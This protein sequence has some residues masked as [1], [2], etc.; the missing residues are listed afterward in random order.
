MSRIGVK[1]PSLEL[2]ERGRGWFINLTSRQR[3][4]VDCRRMIVESWYTAREIGFAAGLR[5]SE[6]TPAFILQMASVLPPNISRETLYEWRRLFNADGAF[7]LIDL[8]WL[9]S[10]PSAAWPF[11]RTLAA[12]Y[13]RSGK[14][15]VLCH[16][17]ALKAAHYHGWPRCTLSESTR[18]IRQHLM[19]SRASA[20]E[21]DSIGL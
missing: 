15:I 5:E 19:Q 3:S 11:I 16:D 17:D 7:G 1:Q 13:R 21:G 6:I 9:R 14:R 4:I 18:W 20:G 8:R 2:A 10:K 12:S